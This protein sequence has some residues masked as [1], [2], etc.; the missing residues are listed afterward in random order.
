MTSDSKTAALRKSPVKLVLGTLVALAG[1][2]AFLM[3]GA[4]AGLVLA[5]MIG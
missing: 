5:G 2:G 1:A 3:V 4:V